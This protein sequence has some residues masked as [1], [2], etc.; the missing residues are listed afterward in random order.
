MQAMGPEPKGG[1]GNNRH[2]LS[3]L[4][5]GRGASYSNKSVSVSGG[6]R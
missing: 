4:H 2:Y 5:W 1:T 3:P 6:K